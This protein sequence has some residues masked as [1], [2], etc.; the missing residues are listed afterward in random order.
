MEIIEV[1]KSKKKKK[2]EKRKDTSKAQKASFLYRPRIIVHTHTL[3]LSLPHIHT[4]SFDNYRKR[5]RTGKGL[6]GRVEISI[7]SSR[8]L[9]LFRDFSRLDRRESSFHPST[10][11]VTNRRQIGHLILFGL[12]RKKKCLGLL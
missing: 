10:F 8:R 9:S 3:S 5:K 4:H 1:I 2:K 6:T 11:L 12:E 7:G